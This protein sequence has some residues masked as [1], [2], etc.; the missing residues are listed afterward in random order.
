[1]QLRRN[2]NHTCPGNRRPCYEINFFFH[3]TRHVISNVFDRIHEWAHFETNQ[4]N[5]DSPQ[6]TVYVLNVKS[7]SII[8]LSQNI[9]LFS[10]KSL[11]FPQKFH[12]LMHF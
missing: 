3:A 5:Q 1:M 6:V 4:S 7:S 11:G 10:E 2:D 8:P 12:V 9:G